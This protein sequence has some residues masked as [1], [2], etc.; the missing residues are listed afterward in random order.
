MTP[1]EVKYEFDGFTLRDPTV[2]ERQLAWV[3]SKDDPEHVWEAE[4]PDY[5]QDRKPG[6]E[7]WMLEDQRGPVFFAKLIALESRGI[8]VTLQ[9]AP[10]LG[11]IDGMAFRTMDALY[12]GMRWL[13]KRLRA[14]GVN[15]VYFNTKNL[16]LMRFALLRL[17]FDEIENDYE[18]SKALGFRRFRKGLA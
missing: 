5:W 7:I 15:A 10:N 9:F 13:E 18:P 3:W 17:G 14:V 12:Y 4:Q 6:S 1:C 2:A 16:Q 11:G 8:E